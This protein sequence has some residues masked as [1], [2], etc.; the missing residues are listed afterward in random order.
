MTAQTTLR[1]YNPTLRPRRQLY[2]S[3]TQLYDRADNFTLVL[4]NFTTAKAT[5]R[6]YNPTLEPRDQ[7]YD[8]TSQLYNRA[9]NSTTV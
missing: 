2:A 4:H 9:A 1:P 5:P 8:C 3:I 6:P 7:L